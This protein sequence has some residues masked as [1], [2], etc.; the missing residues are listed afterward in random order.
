VPHDRWYKDGLIYEA[1]VRWFA[2]SD[3]DGKGDLRGMIERLDHLAGLG[4]TCLW[5]LPFQPSPLR[6]DGYDVTDH[7]AVHPD[8]GDL[9][10]F[11]DL[12][13]ETEARGMRVITDLV[14]N[15]TSDEHPWFRAARERHPRYHDYYVWAD[16]EPENAREGMV[17]PGVQETT[18]T[19]DEVARRWYFHRFYDFQPDLNIANPEVREE[20]K[21]II[22]FWVELGVAGFRLDAVPFLIEPA[23][24]EGLRPGPKLEFLE[25][26]RDQMSWW[27]GDAIFLGE[28]NV[29]REQVTDY[30]GPGGMHML[31][32]FQANQAV[33]LA[34]AR[35]DARP[36]VNALKET[37]G[38]PETDQWA[39]FLRNHDE[40]DLGRLTDDE[41]RDAFATFGPDRSMQAYGRGIRRR[42]GPML[43]GDQRRCE[44]A[45]SVLLSQ[46]GTPVLYYGDEVAM[47]DD[48]SKPERMSVRTP[49][50]WDEVA[51]QNRDPDSLLNRLARAVQARRRMQEFGIA[52]WEAIDT[53]EPSVLALRF[54]ER[55][56]CVI[57][58][59]NLASE[60]RRAKLDADG[61]YDVLA[62]RQ[63]DPPSNGS[64]DLDA[65]GYRWLRL[66]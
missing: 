21:R 17:F 62:D 63:Y 30:F 10:D 2:D 15:H 53:G 55:D 47:G 35:E 5:L 45:F 61:A 33:W 34:F 57:A 11:I 27:R 60:P 52:G 39:N 49:M 29:Q 48:L 12:I 51:R 7:F 6:D 4:V 40:I 22:A 20:M 19:Y 43:G 26:L 44:L 66:S 18:W 56:R 54:V 36:L 13:H 32:N 3:G 24:A 9:G 25:A 37:T 65:Y 8:L 59:S 38:I 64:V 50:D 28:A 31:F 46:P 1:S 16:E 42:L 23:G 58:L 14:I 41:R